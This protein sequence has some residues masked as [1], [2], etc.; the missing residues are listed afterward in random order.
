MAFIRAHHIAIA[1]MLGKLI[2]HSNATGPAL[3][4]GVET[5]LVGFRSVNTFEA[6]TRIADDNGVAIDNTRR[7]R[8]V[9]CECRC[10]GEQREEYQRVAHAISKFG[11]AVS[12]HDWF[13]SKSPFWRPPLLRM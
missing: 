8:H 13:A 9:S 1:N 5:N 4:F 3:A 6:H 10:C 2:A 11:T 7:A 12:L